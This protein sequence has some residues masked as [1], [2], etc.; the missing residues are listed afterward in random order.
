MIVLVYYNSNTAMM[1]GPMHPRIDTSNP[2]PVRRPLAEQFE[3]ATE[4]VGVRPAQALPSGRELA[5]FLDPNMITRAI[6]ELKRSGYR[7]LHA[8]PEAPESLR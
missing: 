5:G 8:G 7:P 2:I 6:E 4:G 1:E 3:P